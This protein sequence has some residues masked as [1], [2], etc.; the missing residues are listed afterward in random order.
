MSK[1]TSKPLNSSI[2]CDCSTTKAHRDS[3]IPEFWKEVDRGD[4]Y[5]VY[6]RT[7]RCCFCGKRPMLQYTLRM[8]T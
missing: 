6:E 4:D 2:S 3:V 1:Q 7:Y 5:V 8:R